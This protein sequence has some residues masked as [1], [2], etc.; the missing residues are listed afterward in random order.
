MQKITE[1][2][3]E[4]FKNDWNSFREKVL[5]N[6]DTNKNESIL[7]RSKQFE[8]IPEDYYH[9]CL[10][11]K[12]ILDQGSTGRCWM[13]AGLNFLRNYFLENNK[14]DDILFSPSYLY[15]FDKLEKA[16]YFLESMITSRSENLDDRMLQYWLKNPCSDLGQWTMF[17]NL[18]TKYGLVP[19]E[20]MPDTVD[21]MQS[22]R[23]TG[24]INDFLRFCAK[25]IRDSQSPVDVLR[26]K[27]YSMLSKVYCIL[28]SCLG[29][30][31]EYVDLKS[32]T[33]NKEG[34]IKPQDWF[35][36]LFPSMHLS[37]Y[38]CLIDAPNLNY[39]QFYELT[40]V[41]NVVSSTPIR[42]LNIPIDVII[43]CIIKQLQDGSSIWFGCDSAKY[44]DYQSGFFD[45]GIHLSLPIA[46][47]PLLHMSKKDRL[48][49]GCSIMTHAMNIVGVRYDE[50][51]NPKIWL[52]EN[53]KGSSFGDN[54]Y[55][56]ITNDWLKEFTYQVVVSSEYLDK[57]ITEKASSIPY[58]YLNPWEPLGSLASE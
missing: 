8:T 28:S 45:L 22:Y 27:K 54:G 26:K 11:K 34:L 32:V 55:I 31:P 20:T 21:S 33:N 36:C 7:K 23:L 9:L 42:Y 15:F 3:F 4:T 57:K 12:S 19:F 16:N 47:E 13:F 29:T 10:K 24:E 18:I 39:Y 56:H 35:K 17:V 37:K 51:Q 1:N 52:V 2:E 44:Y 41:Q 30:P 5:K 48:T 25:D 49:Y 58:G 14:V 43:E 53:S 38:V 40:G 6:I 50:M 46:N